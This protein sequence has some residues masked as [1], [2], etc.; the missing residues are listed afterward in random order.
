[1]AEDIAWTICEAELLNGAVGR[2]RG[3]RR[4]S[5][6]PVEVFLLNNIDLP[7]MID[8]EVSWKEIQPSPLELMAARGVVLDCKP[9]TRGLWPVVAAVVTGCDRS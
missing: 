7:V 9:G 3:I 2:A 1:M 4:T 6:N 8:R 5:D